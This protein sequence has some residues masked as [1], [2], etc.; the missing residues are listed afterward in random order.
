MPEPVPWADVL[1]RQAFDRW[2]ADIGS[3]HGLQPETLRPA[4]ADASF[5]RYL[6]VQAGCGS[7]IIMDAPPQLEDV[8]PFIRVAA[9]IRDA[10]LHA[11][12][13]LAADPAQGFLLLTDLGDRLYLDALRD[14]DAATV[15]RLIRDAL[16][17]LVRWQQ[18]V[19]AAALP[20][21]DAQRMA[22]EMDL[23]LHWCVQRSFGIEWT[24]A[25]KQAWA[26][27]VQAIVARA[28]AQ[29]VVAVH[30]DWM[31]RNLMVMPPPRTG[32][33][34]LGNPGIL[35]FQDA[36]AGP[37]TYDLVS[38]LR[39]AYLS[40][41]EAQQIDWA[42]R[43]WHAARQAGLPLGD[44]AQDFGAFWEALEW[45]GLQRHLRILGVFCRLRLRD[46]KPQY[47]AE[48][49]RF[50]GYVTQVALRYPALKPLLRLIEPMS[51]RA[52][53]SGWTF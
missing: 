41:D 20:A 44:W 43:Y 33:D 32:G 5:R 35:D 29:P 9:L 7:L 30:A 46:G 1:R 18:Q 6:R 16:T 25:Q 42:V 53:S 31:P 38:L 12:Q 3:A 8:Q 26:G 27:V 11:P 14:S 15:D 24:A 40:W 19:P 21:F 52:L 17:A 45:M 13:V 39:D 2:L 47:A 34:A 37:I 51:G 48:L 50:F 10:G 4:S 36:F 23:F 28:A 49:P 22:Q